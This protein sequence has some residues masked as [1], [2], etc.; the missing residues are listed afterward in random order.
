[1]PVF[2]STV[3]AANSNPQAKEK[4]AELLKNARD[5]VVGI[6]QDALGGNNSKKAGM[7]SSNVPGMGRSKISIR[8]RA[9]LEK[10]ESNNK[11]KR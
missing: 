1:M 8:K 2:E 10:G 11:K 6:A 5:V 3:R 9:L 4:A 7:A